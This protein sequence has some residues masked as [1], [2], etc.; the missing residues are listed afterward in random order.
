MV[1]L[2]HYDIKIK[3]AGEVP[4]KECTSE[5]TKAFTEIHDICRKKNPIQVHVFFLTQFLK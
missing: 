3:H 4:R 2:K 1:S 5:N